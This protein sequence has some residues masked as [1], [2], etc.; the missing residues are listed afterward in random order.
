MRVKVFAA[1]LVLSWAT[2]S[3]AQAAATP[4]PFKFEMHGFASATIFGQDGT[5]T[6]GSGQTA[7][8]PTQAQPKTD[9]WMLGGDVRQT[10][11][12]WSVTG[13]AVMGG[14][15]PKAVLEIDWVQGFGGGNQGEVHLLPRMR[16]AYSELNWGADRLIF[17]QNYDLT[18]A[19]GPVTLAHLGAPYT[20]SAGAMAF[21]RPGVFYYHTFGDLKDP[22]SGKVEFSAEVGRSQWSDAA[23]TYGAGVCAGNISS[24]VAPPAGSIAGVCAGEASGLPHVQARLAYAQ[25]AN[26]SAFIAG[27][28]QRVD[29]SGYGNVTPD[30][31]RPPLSDMDT[32]GGEAGF[33]AAYGPVNLAAAG[34]YGK[35]LSPL[36]GGFGTLMWPT[37]GDVHE[38]GIWGQLGVN[39][40]KELSAYYFLGVDRINDNDIMNSAHVANNGFSA[41]R[42]V[43]WNAMLQYRDGGYALGLEWLQARANYIDTPTTKGSLAIVNQISFTSNYY[44]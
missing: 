29:R 39:L 17:G 44:F 1:A 12:N 18:A 7:W 6:G 4:S 23:A 40:T 9:T 19:L 43:S 13:P 3:L 10:R 32:V 25:G 42:N 24:G 36:Y 14:A 20:L 28:W 2:T 5:L 38:Y 33:K 34:Y 27:A 11:F 35:N 15:T 41:N 21:R 31:A 22:K 30:N 8:F 37:A 16:L 26:F